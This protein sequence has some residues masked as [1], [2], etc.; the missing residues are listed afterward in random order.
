MRSLEKASHDLSAYEQAKTT[1]PVNKII[2]Q[3]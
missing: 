2:K 3:I 1:T